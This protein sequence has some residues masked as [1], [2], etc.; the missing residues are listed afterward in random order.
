MS[1]L[2]VRLFRDSFS[3]PWGFRLQGGRDIGHPLCIQRVFSNSPAEGELQRGDQVLTIGGRP[4]TELTHQQAQDIVKRGSAQIDLTVFRPA[5]SRVS[6]TAT[7]TPAA[8]RPRAQSL[9]LSPAQPV[10][11]PGRDRLRLNANPCFNP[12]F[13][14]QYSPSSP[15]PPP[16]W[17]QQNSAPKKVSKL[18]EL[19][20]GSPD[21][22][23]DYGAHYG[24]VPR[25]R[26]SGQVHSYT[27]YFQHDG[28][29]PYQDYSLPHVGGGN[30]DYGTDYCTLPRNRGRQLSQP[31]NQRSHPSGYATM[32]ASGGGSGFKPKK[33]TLSRLGGGGP[34][35]GSDFNRS[36]PSAAMQPVHVHTGG[37]YRGGPPP[38]PQHYHGGD[39]LNRVHD[40]L[41]NISLSP[42]TPDYGYQAPPFA[43]ASSPVGGRG[44]GQYIPTGV[45]L[46][47]EREQEL[48]QQQ[49]QQQHQQQYQPQQQQDYQPAPQQQY[50]QQFEPQQQYVATGVRL[51]H[52][53][54]E[55]E[56][57]VDVAPVVERRK[58]F[59]N[60]PAPHAPAPTGKNTAPKVLKPKPGSTNFNFG[61]DYSKPTPKT[62][63]VTW[64]PQPAQRPVNV[65]P[66]PQP[67]AV[68]SYQAP[69]SSGPQDEP[70]QPDMPPAWR[71]SLRTT[72]VKPWD[73]DLEYT[74]DQQAPA[75]PRSVG[76]P[77]ARNPGPP[78]HHPAPAPPLPQQGGEQDG[79]RV[80][81]LQYNSPMG[82]YSK[83]NVCDTFAGQ[84]KAMAASGA[85]PQGTQ[86]QNPEKA[87]DRDW[88]QSAVYRMIYEEEKRGRP[89]H[90]SQPQQQQ[91]P[92][93]APPP[94]APK[95]Q[96][97]TFQQAFNPMDGDYGT[98]DF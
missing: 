90:Q 98:S 67:E 74:A 70:D 53:M 28:G 4:A 41:D 77:P 16:P 81:H 82:L 51:D 68:Q 7:F 61:V 24:T 84:T 47:M 80:M 56:Q 91:Q 10:T 3:K 38:P 33:V 59:V 60:A 57:G 94:P 11:M 13:I 2:Q 18:S 97:Q 75:Q 71:T 29:S 26:H 39:M 23:V 8:Q 76:Y 32:P 83:Q 9:Q 15:H 5:P 19:G 93:P 27:Q 37:G 50:Y 44:G 12:N 55:E 65:P 73:N 96:M 20:G 34:D 25:R 62:S 79:P 54:G 85:I 78:N 92:K 30:F 58:A 46:D 88:T 66:P 42:R 69:W 17:T 45:R 22:G 43:A 63:T 40:S 64:R 95:P 86:M 35:F 31:P 21:F 48:R 49:Q 1:Q 89:Q 14:H 36:R 87:G 6:T 52:Q 72:G